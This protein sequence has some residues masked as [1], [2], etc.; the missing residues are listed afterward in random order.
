MGSRLLKEFSFG[1]TVPAGGEK[2]AD[3]GAYDLTEV[4]LIEVGP[5]L[6]GIN[7]DTELL[8]LK[9]AVSAHNKRKSYEFLNTITTA[10]SKR[11]SKPKRM[12]DRPAQMASTVTRLGSTMRIGI[13]RMRGP[14]LAW[15][16]NFLYCVPTA[17]EIRTRGV[18]ATP[19]NSAST[20]SPPTAV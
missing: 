16:S 3:D 12:P 2:K 19:P 13:S 8:S 5:T 20:V 15:A 14:P 11:P 18:P 6:K 7:P 1:Y 4:N 9:S 17:Q 10:G